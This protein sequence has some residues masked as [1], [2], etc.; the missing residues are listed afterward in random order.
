MSP[1]CSNDFTGAEVVLPEGWRVE[2]ARDKREKEKEL[3]GPGKRERR[4]RD[5]GG[6]RER[7]GGSTGCEMG[8]LGLLGQEVSS[9]IARKNP[10]FIKLKHRHKGGHH[11]ELWVYPTSNWVGMVEGGLSDLSLKKISL[12]D[13]YVHWRH[14]RLGNLAIVRWMMK[15]VCMAGRL[16]ALQFDTV[17]VHGCCGAQEDHGT[18]VRHIWPKAMV[19]K[20]RVGAGLLS[21][22]SYK[23]SLLKAAAGGTSAGFCL[24][25]GRGRKKRNWLYQ[26]KVLQCAPVCSVLMGKPAWC[27]EAAH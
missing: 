17:V 13:G 15:A 11:A 9:R 1:S 16:L 10:A 20:W 25:W 5:R 22:P 18:Q 24:M 19:T 27:H 4:D 26:G 8:W 14:W 2:G 6:Q 21:R 12:R 23:I 3:K 7:R